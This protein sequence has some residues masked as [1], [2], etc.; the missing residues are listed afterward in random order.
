MEEVFNETEYYKVFNCTSDPTAAEMF[1][2]FEHNPAGL[3]CLIIA[4]VITAVQTVIMIDG[5][6]WIS[7]NI[8]HAE[9]SSSMIWL[10]SIWPVF[11]IV[12]LCGLYIPKAALLSNAGANLFLFPTIYNYLALLVDYFGGEDAMISKMKDH[13]IKYSRPPCCCCCCCCPPG[14]CSR[15]LKRKQFNRL[16]LLV[17]QISV[18][19][20][21]LLFL[22]EMFVLDGTFPV[23]N[24]FNYMAP[25]LYIQILTVGSTLT[26]MQ[27]LGTLNAS[28]RPHLKQYS[29]QS[30]FLIVQFA[31]LMCNV[32]NT[33]INFI[34]NGLGGCGNP[35]PYKS[36]D[37]IWNCF[38]IILE[39]LIFQPICIKYLRTLKG[40]VLFIP[41]KLKKSKTYAGTSL[42]KAGQKGLLEEATEAA[43]LDG[44]SEKTPLVMRRARSHS[45]IKEGY[46][47]VITV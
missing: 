38:L 11:C 24:P 5:I 9:R 16:E 18:V 12:S 22:S 28:C 7:K 37:Y 26:A 14:M 44:A 31:L 27:V 41:Q 8:P 21:L 34:L 45:D 19:R 23:D 1:T 25:G 13:P 20:P 30:K 36:R 42:M 39:S 33:L 47:S 40:N 29:T 35:Y 43:D 2:F 15:V 6:V 32:Q 3:V 4:T 10:Y 17:M 46:G